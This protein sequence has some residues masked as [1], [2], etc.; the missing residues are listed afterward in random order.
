MVWKAERLVSV[1]ENLDEDELKR[2]KL[3]LSDSPI[4]G[5]YDNIPRGRLMK[6]DVLDLSLL[7][8]GFYMEDAVQVAAE[9]LRAINCRPEAERLISL[10]E[11]E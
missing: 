1:L 10:S 4:R 8:L 11:T 5:G 3:N 2:F 6:A 9:V 7:L